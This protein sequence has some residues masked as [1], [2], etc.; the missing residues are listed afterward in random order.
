MALPWAILV[1]GG[2]A[3]LLP[4]ISPRRWLSNVILSVLGL[5]LLVVLPRYLQTIRTGARVGAALAWLTVL[6]AGLWLWLDPFGGRPLYDP[7]DCVVPLRTTQLCQGTDDSFI[8]CHYR[9]RAEGEPI[10]SRCRAYLAIDT[11]YA[12]P[13]LGCD[14]DQPDAWERVPCAS[15]GLPASMQCF[16]CVS[17][18]PEQMRVRVDAFAADCGREVML[19]ACNMSLN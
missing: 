18:Q 1:C 17:Q 9:F 15:Y 13:G 5:I 19:G 11:A 8:D 6:P 2:L 16:T 4:G 10:L 12:R 7:G 3:R 14:Y